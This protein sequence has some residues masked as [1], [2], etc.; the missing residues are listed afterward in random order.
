MANISLIIEK[1]RNKNGDRTPKFNL[2]LKRA[3][4]NIKISLGQTLQFARMTHTRLIMDKFRYGNRDRTL[5]L[6]V[7]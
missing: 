5:K 7:Y 3:V 2:L 6:I 1:F 4:A